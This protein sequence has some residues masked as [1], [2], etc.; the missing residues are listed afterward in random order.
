MGD[1]FAP[2]DSEQPSGP[3]P[4]NARIL[5]IMGVVGILGTLA[6][7]VYVSPRFSAGVFIGTVIALL[8]YVWLK[9]SLAGIFAAAAEGERP[10][11][12]VGRYFLRYLVLGFAVA[13]VYITG[14][15]SIAGLILGMTAFGFATVIEGFIRI[16]SNVFSEKEV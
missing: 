15:V 4:S 1:E 10:R 13:A 12:M 6:G 16:F 14:A 5:W 8:N 9:R 2:P 7:A 11:M 3:P